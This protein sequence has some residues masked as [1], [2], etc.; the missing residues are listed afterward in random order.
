MKKM[1]STINILVHHLSF[2]ITVF[3]T[4]EFT[5]FLLFYLF[6]LDLANSKMYRTDIFNLFNK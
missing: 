3:L 4:G 5:F 1:C 6:K 2:L